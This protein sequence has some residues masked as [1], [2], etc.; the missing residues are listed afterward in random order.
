LT[1]QNG[2]VLSQYMQ[3]SLPLN[4]AFCGSRNSS[5]FTF[6]NRSQWTGLQGAPRTQ[7]LSIHTVLKNE[8]IAPGLFITNEQ[9]GI[10]KS[11][12][13]FGNIAYRTRIR[14]GTFSLGLASGVFINTNSWQDVI[15]T[16]GEDPSI[17]MHGQK[18]VI[19]DASFG[20]YYF[21]KNY[22][23]SLSVPFLLSHSVEVSSG[24]ISIDNNFE[25]YHLHLAG[26]YIHKLNRQWSLRPSFLL[27]HQKA[28]GPQIDINA[29]V[30][31][32]KTVVAGVS[33]RSQDAIL[34]LC[35][36]NISR[37]F[38]LGYTYDF[39]LSDL[40]IVSKGSHEI[41]LQYDLRYNTRAANPKFF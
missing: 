17:P 11:M 16:T 31:Y 34:F 21:T 3:N 4:P 13:V 10:S 19:P 30:E 1:A 15:T 22:F 25:N 32:K 7:T 8:N 6:S 39:T 5:S 23:V 12:G 24:N 37:Q 38:G 18:V 26:G 36:Y 29:L 20:T 2:T 35:K 14:K 40:S 27:K 28:F 41:T 33:Y 9:I